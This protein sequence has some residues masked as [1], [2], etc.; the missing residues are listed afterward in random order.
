MRK[1]VFILAMA[2]VFV[3]VNSVQAA[4]VLKKDNLTYQIKG[5]W[6]IQ[7]RQDPGTEQDFDLEYDDLELKNSISYDLGNGLS[8]F[9][10]L[11]FGFNS[12]LDNSDNV[13]T[14]HIEEAY[15]GIKVSDWKF[16]V[17]RTD[18]AAD[19]FG[20]EIALEGYGIGDDVFDEFGQLKGD[21][22]IMVIGK[23]ANMVDV[24]AAYEM[25]ADSESSSNLGGTHY[26][27]YAAVSFAGFKVGAAYQQYNPFERDP[28]T[29]SDT[30]DDVINI[31]GVMVSYDAKVVKIGIDYGVASADEGSGL[32]EGSVLNVA[33]TVPAGP[34]TI[35]AGYVMM[36]P[37]DDAADDVNEWYANI[38]FKFQSAKNVSLFAEIG[39]N[40]IDDYDMGY[41]A[42]M[43]I[44]F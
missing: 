5:D 7:F 4:T 23:I 35:G 13:N 2:M 40:D 31:W 14:D 44:T 38:A 33:V 3:A 39:D 24:R 20:V 29:D 17:G 19:E 11:D 12:A 41:L 36:S 18:T 28:V 26:D 42:G 10:E 30:S 6:Q 34:V 9:G 8:A 1:I 27:V 37:E 16:L 32:D 15:L 25:Q 21:D 43:R 22:L